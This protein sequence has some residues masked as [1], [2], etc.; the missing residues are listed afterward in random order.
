MANDDASL[1]RL[2]QL[3]LETLDFLKPFR[4]V[5]PLWSVRHM[6][7]GSDIVR[8]ETAGGREVDAGEE[9][10]FNFFDLLLFP[11]PAEPSDA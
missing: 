11:V 1:L 7:I 3:L 9:I 5:L 10:G 2:A 6:Y 4:V 8:N